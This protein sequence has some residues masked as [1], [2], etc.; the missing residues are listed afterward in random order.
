MTTPLMS[1]E[2]FGDAAVRLGLV[3][4]EQIR[5]CLEIQKKL[6][7]MGIRESLGEILVRQGYIEQDQIQKILRQTK[8][9]APVVPGYEILD[10]VGQGGAA[11]VYRARQMRG[12]RIVALKVLLPWA[13]KNPGFVQRFQSEA[14]TASRLVHP[15]L[16]RAYDSGQIAGTYY[17]AMEFVE[18]R[19]AYE[20]VREKGPFPER[21]ALNIVLQAARALDYLQNKNLIHRDVKPENIMVTSDGTAKLCDFGILLSVESDEAPTKGLTFGTPAYMSPEQIRGEKY[22]DIR[23]DLYALGGTLFFLLTGRPPFEAKTTRELLT[24]HLTEP[25]PSPASFVSRVSPETCQITALLL[26]KRRE[27]RYPRPKHLIKDLRA[28]LSGR[29]PPVAAGVKP[30]FARSLAG[31]AAALVLIAGSGAILLSHSGRNGTVVP[32]PIAQES[33]TT[34]TAAPVVPAPP[35]PDEARAEELFRRASE[36]WLTGRKEEARAA[37]REIESRFAATRTFA[38]HKD[39]LAKILAREDP[40]VPA[41]SSTPT[42]PPPD[43]LPAPVSDA[44]HQFEKACDLMNA[45]QWKEA[46]EAFRKI[47]AA[48]LPP[49]VSEI[50]VR[51]NLDACDRELAASEFFSRLAEMENTGQWSQLARGITVF[52]DQYRDTTTLAELA[53]RLEEMERRIRTEQFV[54]EAIRLA[55]M[56]YQEEKWEEA[57]GGLDLVL[58]DYADTYT[59]RT[60]RAELEEMRNAARARLMEP[61]EAQARAKIAHAEQ[62]FKNKDYPAAGRLYDQLLAEPL[63]S[64]EA[65]KSLGPALWE[66]RKEVDRLLREALE[67]LAADTLR[68]LETLARRRKWKEAQEGLEILRGKC[69]DTEAVRE[70]QAKILRLAEQIEAALREEQELL[71]DDMEGGPKGWIAA[72]DDPNGKGRVEAAGEPRDVKVGTGAARM[73]FPVH[74][75]RWSFLEKKLE[76]GIPPNAHAVTFFARGDGRSCRI[77]IYFRQGSGD[78]EALFGVEAGLGVSYMRF[79]FAFSDVRHVWSRAAE[80]R[81][82][83]PAFQRSDVRS[84]IIAQ[85]STTQASRFL[86]DDLRFEAR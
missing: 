21:Q 36:A 29:P 53:P 67:E 30:S 76:R 9:D 34:P 83:Q 15:N 72:S 84:I 49:E 70:S 20:L 63:V 86:I 62:A 80:R 47:L 5:E 58:R 24:K 14:R 41:P 51:A 78:T 31:A 74:R 65:V 64:T 13:A 46:A 37:A 45:K 12:G 54:E 32:A 25:P 23:A 4:S 52:Q 44:R 79:R 61:L 27:F 17:F 71:I 77:R 16:V 42:P 55:L 7:E 33:T 6:Q 28:V 26:E 38:D 56:R 59:V 3:N 39:E 2:K 40:V 43:N 81:L 66:R 35:D 75:G 48:P 85:A 57:A 60:R 73:S 50:D 8:F 11:T 1:S 18:G 82:P 69:K 10:R 19:T 68:E 22:L